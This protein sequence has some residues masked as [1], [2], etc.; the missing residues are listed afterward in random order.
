MKKVRQ[1]FSH[2]FVPG[3]HNNYR[4][5]AL[6]QGTLVL[7]LF[8]FLIIGFA[9]Q[10]VTKSDNVLGY[11]TDITIPKLLQATNAQRAKYGAPK[12]VLND[13]LSEA[14]T[15]KGR[16][17]FAK[18]YWAHFGPNGETPWQFFRD[19]DYEYE[20]AGENLAKNFLFSQGV[21]DAWM[22]SKTHREN[23]L[24]RDYTDVG[25]AV[26]N[27]SLNGEETTLVV[28]EFGKPLKGSDIPLSKKSPNINLGKLPNTPENTARVQGAGEEQEIVTS[29][30]RFP[31]WD[32]ITRILFNVNILFM[33]FFLIALSFDFYF[34]SKLHIVRLN[35]KSLAHFIYVLF[36]LVALVMIAKGAIL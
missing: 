17:M 34:A 20:F 18:N 28:Q 4:S 29:S 13:K 32:N 11:A 24:R 26:I 9:Y 19:A 16:D 30:P 25:F 35:G 33:V 23:L 21:V 3:S 27:G 36:I 6:R 15:N 2:L 7:Y 1:F 12:L 8:T 10:Y 22:N 31:F 14:A 5:L